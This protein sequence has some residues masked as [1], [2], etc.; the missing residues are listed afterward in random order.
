[1]GVLFTAS[2][3]ASVCRELT[4]AILASAT[5]PQVSHKSAAKHRL[6]A[7]FVLEIHLF[8]SRLLTNAGTRANQRDQLL[9]CRHFAAFEIFFVSSLHRSPLDFWIRTLVAS[10]SSCLLAVTHVS[11]AIY[12]VNS[13][14]ATSW[15]QESR[16]LPPSHSASLP[17]Y[18]LAELCATLQ[19][20]LCLEC[21]HVGLYTVTV[22]VHRSGEE[23]AA[24][25]RQRVLTTWLISTTRQAMRREINTGTWD[26]PA[27]IA[28]C[29]RTAGLGII[30]CLHSSPPTRLPFP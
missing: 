15:S 8:A 21:L 9:A 26:S 22:Q 1:L 5:L 20:H 24:A 18:H 23:A 28:R 25:G 14:S 12:L 7:F 29:R 2:A 10:T 27:P 19:A 3:V 30:P 4:G 17:V 11:S 16:T 13:P 6:R